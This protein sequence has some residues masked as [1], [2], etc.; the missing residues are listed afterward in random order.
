M[1]FRRM[2]QGTDADFLVLKRVHTNNVAALPSLLLRMLTELK[3]DEAFPVDR[4]THSLQS[5]TL[6]MR[7]GRDEEYIVCCLFHDIGES[8]GPFNHGEVAAAVLR[9]FISIDNY[10]ML[11][12]HPTFQTYYYGPHLGIDPNRARRVHHQPVLRPNRRVLCQVRRGGLRPR[13]LGRAHLDLRA[14]GPAGPRQGVDAPELSGPS[15]S[16]D[17]D[18][19]ARRGA[20]R[21]ARRRPGWPSK[22]PPALPTVQCEDGAMTTERIEVQRFIP[23]ESRGHL[24]GPVRPARPRRH[25]QLRHAPRRRPETS[26]NAVGDS[27]VVH[28]DREALSDYP[29]GRYDVTVHITTLRARPRDRLDHPRPTQPSVTSTGTGW[30]PPTV[31]PWSRRTTTGRQSHPSGE[32]PESFPSSPRV[33]SG[34]P[35]ASSTAPSSPA[36]VRERPPALRNR[37][38]TDPESAAPHRTPPG[39]GPGSQ[40]VP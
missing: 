7:D 39:A 36:A 38:A 29:M 19:E 14:N 16:V 9:P 34:Q 13:L 11:A 30:S 12:H 31:A 8:L 4:L 6:A 17:R 32:K 15:S 5:A 21:R 3:A 18:G 28:M 10:W 35:S 23:A 26:V 2:D 37:G 27:F 40:P 1:H 22:A 25:R 20:D 33:R 24:P